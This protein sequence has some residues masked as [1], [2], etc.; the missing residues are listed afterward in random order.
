MVEMEHLEKKVVHKLWI[1][2]EEEGE[3]ESVEDKE[4]LGRNNK[5]K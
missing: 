5:N 3:G 2:E 4:L 1:V